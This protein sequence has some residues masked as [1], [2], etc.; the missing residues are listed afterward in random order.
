MDEAIKRIKKDFNSQLEI[1]SSSSEIDQIKV[2]F[3]GKKGPIQDLMRSLKDVSREERPKVG[4]MINDLKEELSHSCQHTFDALL[5]KEE[6]IK[7]ESQKMDVTL[8]GRKR[9]L[10]RPHP[11]TQIV[12]DILAIF[13]EM[14]FSIQYGPNIESDFYNFE[15]LNFP[16]DHPARDMQDTFYFSKEMLLRTHTSN[17]QVRLMEKEDLPIRVAC[18]GKAFRNEN[19]SAR[20]HVFFHQIEGVY[21]DKGVSF[22]DLL[23]TLKAFFSKIF[24]REIKMRFR[25]SYFPFVEPGLEAD[26]ECLV[27]S[28]KGCKI[29]KETG[30]LE[31]AGAGMIHPNVLKAGKIDPEEYSGFAWCFGIERL[32]MLLHNIK[33]IRLFTENDQ[34]FLSQF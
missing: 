22:G 30:W 8:P 2:R 12:T 20:S 21:I 34:R 3:L 23:A 11:I 26:I 29:C 9:F 32:Q 16:E 24:K 1:A 5:H 13:K 28:A 31:V 15:S 17:I 18:P 19:I 27:C 10:G 6:K 14:G 7:L 25:A 33:D 4:K